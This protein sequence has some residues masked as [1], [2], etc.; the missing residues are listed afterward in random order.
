VFDIPLMLL[1]TYD[2]ISLG[3][4]FIHV[5]HKINCKSEELQ[6]YRLQCDMLC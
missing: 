6:I 1:Y 2:N 5:Q 3:T 4:C